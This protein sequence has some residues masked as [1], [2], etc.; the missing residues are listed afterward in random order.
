MLQPGKGATFADLEGQLLKLSMKWAETFKKAWAEYP[1][2]RT[3]KK[4][5][6]GQAFL[7]C[8]KR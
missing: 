5:T 2:E 6:G 8:C 1:H 3:A 7:T 4:T